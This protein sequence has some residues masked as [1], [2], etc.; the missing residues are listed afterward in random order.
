MVHCERKV[1]PLNDHHLM[2]RLPEGGVAA[3]SGMALGEAW[4]F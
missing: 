1:I 2:A 4:A 3:A